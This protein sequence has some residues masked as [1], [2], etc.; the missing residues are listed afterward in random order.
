MDLPNNPDE[1]QGSCADKSQSRGVPGWLS[2]LSVQPLILAQVLIFG[3]CGAYLKK[4]SQSQKV[5]YYMIP[6]MQPS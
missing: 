2:W 6:F 5:N 4:K 1:S 3:L